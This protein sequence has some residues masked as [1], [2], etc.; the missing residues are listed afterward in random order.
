[1]HDCR[2]TDIADYHSFHILTDDRTMPD[3]PVAIDF[4]WARELVERG[5][6]IVVVLLIMSVASLTVAVA[7]LIQ[8]S[9]G[10]VG[11]RS[12]FESALSAWISGEH[13]RALARLSGRRSATA[14]VL[15]HAMRALRMNTSL[16]L[17]REDA[18]RVASEELVALR[19]YLRVIEATAQIAPLL[20]LFG[21]VIGMMG[22][23]QA[24]QSAGSATDPAA[25]AGGIWVALIT[26]AVGLAV[27]IPASATLYWFDGRIEKERTNMEAALTSLFTRRLQGS[28]S[29]LARGQPHGP[30]TATSHRPDQAD[31]AE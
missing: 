26:T 10:G 31:A 27:A 15:A 6:P 13:D 28:P 3:L 18:E 17:V 4:T 5:G 19:A 22:A 1:M 23:F 20:G 11:R 12:G 25:L 2:A 24:L 9:V 8:F 29:Q 7:K 30:L 16:E 14:R 21:T